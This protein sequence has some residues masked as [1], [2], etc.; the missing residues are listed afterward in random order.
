MSAF[1]QLC[2]HLL[3]SL[4][5]HIHVF[6]K[7]AVLCAVLCCAV[8]HMCCCR[9]ACDGHGTTFCW[10]VIFCCVVTSPC[11]ALCCVLQEGICMTLKPQ[12]HFLEVA[13][14]Y[15]ARCAVVVSLLRCSCWV[16]CFLIG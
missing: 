3:E 7:G 10:Q 8:Q 1:L 14:P 15:V 4:D 12:F 6:V 5:M 9:M 2:R 13:Y 16:R 11:S